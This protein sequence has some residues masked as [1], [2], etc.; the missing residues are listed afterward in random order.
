MLELWGSSFSFDLVLIGYLISSFIISTLRFSI[1]GPNFPSWI[2]TQR[3]LEE[4]D[5]FS[6][7]ISSTKNDMF[8]NFVRGIK[9]T[10]NMSNNFIVRDL[11]N[12]LLNTK[13]TFLAS[14][15]LKGRLLCISKNVSMLDLSHNS[16]LGSISPLLCNTIDKVFNGL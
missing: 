9:C 15:N 11:L 12:M 4:L 8:W 10:L 14:N 7:G 3:S 6:K 16:F 5:I 1:L 13:Y 2:Y